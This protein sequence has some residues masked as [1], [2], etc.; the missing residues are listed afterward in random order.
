MPRIIYYYQ[1]F[2]SL[3]PIL[4]E[5][6]PITHIHLSAI[7]FGK[8]DDNTPYIH[9]ND[10]QPNDSI[11]DKVWQELED[12]EKYD[13]KTILMVGGAGGAFEN[14]FLNFNIYYPLLKELILTKKIIKGID[15]DIE[16]YVDLKDVKNFI[17]KIKYDFGEDFIITMA[18]VQSAIQEDY[19]GMGGF[20]YKDLYNSKEGKKIEYFNGQFYNS[21]TETAYTQVIENQYQ[22][23]KIVMGMISGENFESELNKTFKKYNQKFGGVFI[24]EYFNSPIGWEK[25]VN[26]IMS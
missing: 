6:T 13:I 14:L 21:Y 4:Y 26:K 11:F 16:E 10:H 17:N 23:D 5:N 7:H 2:N 9:L 12:A 24:W 1:T 18:P 8:N 15:L 3:N 25:I 22:P 19:P 20:V